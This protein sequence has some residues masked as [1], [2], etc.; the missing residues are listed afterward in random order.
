M[1]ILAEPT[2]NKPARDRFR[3]LMPTSGS[4]RSGLPRIDGPETT[5]ALPSGLTNRLR[6]AE[7]GS[8]K[9]AYL[10]S[11]RGLRSSLAH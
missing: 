1:R 6:I 9:A 4:G 3:V 11:S 5:A 2:P 8:N 7:G 10:I